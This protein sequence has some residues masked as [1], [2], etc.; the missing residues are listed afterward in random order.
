MQVIHTVGPVWQD[1]VDGQT[2]DLYEAVAKAL[3][4][5]DKRNLTTVSR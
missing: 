2:D 4:E 3:V 1:G 5:A